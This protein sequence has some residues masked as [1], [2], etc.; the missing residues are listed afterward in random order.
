MLNMLVV[1]FKTPP[2]AATTTTFI[3]III[4]AVRV[5]TIVKLRPKIDHGHNNHNHISSTIVGVFL[6]IHTY[7]HTVGWLFVHGGEHNNNNNNNQRE[8]EREN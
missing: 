1:V 8:R 5:L 6:N 2:P 4:I 3:I 7:I